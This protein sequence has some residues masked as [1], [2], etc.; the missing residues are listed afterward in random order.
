MEAVE[1]RG[2][3][4]M[5]GREPVER[6]HEDATRAALFGAEESADRHA[7]TDLMSEDRLL[8]E[9]AGVTAVDPPGLVA[10]GRAGCPGIR[11]R[12]PQG[13]GVA[14]EVGPDQATAGGARRSWDRSK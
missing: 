3:A 12:D 13:Q 14:I 9:T 5:P 7:E 8:G 2:R 1:P 4:G 6:L 10:A 11:G